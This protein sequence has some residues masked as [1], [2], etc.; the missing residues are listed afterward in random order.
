MSTDKKGSAAATAAHHQKVTEAAGAQI[1]AMNAASKP[2]GRKRKGLNSYEEKAIVA[3][4][5]SRKTWGDVEDRYGREIEADVLAGWKE[6][7][8]RRAGAAEQP[9]K[10]DGQG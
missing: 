2:E 5:R 8:E 10:T 3:M 7:L 1:A 9:R 4:L 6:E